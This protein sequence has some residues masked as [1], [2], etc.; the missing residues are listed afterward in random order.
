MEQKK[1]NYMNKYMK[2]RYKARREYILESLGNKCNQCGSLENLEI[3]HINPLI[4]KISFSKNWNTKIDL[5]N[6]ELKGC[7]ILCKSCHD[8]KSL[9]DGSQFK[10]K[11][12]GEKVGISKLK[13]GIKSISTFLIKI[14][15]CVEKLK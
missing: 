3:D 11:V 13:K 15:V 9:V 1:S 10:N 6:N 2:A 8:K 14:K 4:K 12:R 7:Q 5:I